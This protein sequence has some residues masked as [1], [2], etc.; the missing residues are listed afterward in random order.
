MIGYPLDTKVV[1]ELRKVKPHGA[2]VAWVNA[3]P[4]NQLLL[5]AFTIAELQVGVERIR[6]QD[7]Q[8]AIEIEQWLDGL[9]ACYEVLALDAL[10][11]REWATTN[12]A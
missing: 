10:C 5:S 11:F 4:A 8:K 7:K 2:V 6:R 1:S 9:A 3:L 12:G